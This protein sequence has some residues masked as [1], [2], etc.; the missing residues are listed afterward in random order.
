MGKQALRIEGDLSVAGRLLRH[1]SLFIRTE[2]SL[3]VRIYF[4]RSFYPLSFNPAF[5]L[6]SYHIDQPVTR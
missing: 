4:I 2:S 1:S 5:V 6:P 3:F